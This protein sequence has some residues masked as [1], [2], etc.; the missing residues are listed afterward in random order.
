L[1]VGFEHLI[2]PAPWAV[3]PVFSFTYADISGALPG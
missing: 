2:E 3:S 1:T